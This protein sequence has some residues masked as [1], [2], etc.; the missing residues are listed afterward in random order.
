[1]RIHFLQYLF[2]CGMLSINNTQVQI[3][4]EMYLEL[5]KQRKLH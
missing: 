5:S 2:A 3:G 4:L 1:M